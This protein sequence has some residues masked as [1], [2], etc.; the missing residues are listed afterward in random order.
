[1]TIASD[2]VRSPLVDDNV[3]IGYRSDR[4]DVPELFVLGEDA[5]LRS[6]CVL[7]AGSR[8]GARF[9]AGHHVIV[10]EECEI[11]DD[12][13]IWANS[14]IDHHCRIGDGVKIH[15]GCYVAQYSEICAGAFLAP[16]V[17]IANDLYPGRPASS[18]VQAGAYIGPKAQIGVNSTLLPFVAIG[19]GA[20]IGS[21][22]VVTRDVPPGVVAYGVPARP[23]GLVEDL[24][25]VAERIEPHDGSM[26]RFRLRGAP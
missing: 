17:S 26:Q 14:V 9:S 11:G 13:S 18:R 24:L 19:D 21:G 4:P 2:R 15:V 25:D 5:R 3:R 16:G 8:I 7:Y 22:S 10:R 12:V 1:M 20:I 23:R 6:G